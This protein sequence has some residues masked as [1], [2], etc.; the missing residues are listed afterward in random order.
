M[1]H[2]GATRANSSDRSK[3]ALMRELGYRP[4]S[5]AE[6]L[7]MALRHAV[8]RSRRH[9]QAKGSFM[10]PAAILS[11]DPLISYS[12][13]VPR[14][15]LGLASLAPPGKRDAW[16]LISPTWSTEEPATVRM[17]RRHA[18][19]HRLRHSH[20]RLIFLCNTPEEQR[21]LRE[22]GE[23]AVFLNKTLS[24]P[25]AIFRPIEGVS[26]EFDAIYNAQLAPWKRHELTLGIERCAFICYRAETRPERQAFETE[27]FA[28]HA[29][30]APGHVFLN[31]VDEGG[32]PVRFLPADVNRQLGRAAVGLCLSAREG[33]MF[34]STEYLLAGLPVVTTPS[35]GG[36]HIHFDPEYCL[37]VPPDPRSIAEAVAAMKAKEIPRGYVRERTLQRLDRDRCRFIELINRILVASDTASR[38]AMPWPFRKPV[39]MEW[40][41]AEA[42]VTR[43]VSGRVDAF[44]ALEQ[45][46]ALVGG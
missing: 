12:G 19:V 36:R 45:D 38:L 17:L 40:L 24:V 21:L 34:A 39:I 42:A 29:R 43:A 20:H 33:A 23:A 6:F 9:F 5:A 2:V 3:P 32:A 25:E 41:T 28:R 31:A 10:L 35:T 7:R 18:A 15:P 16:F 26:V 13:M 14:A 30:L 8:A 4:P 27:L 46:G 11:A 44:E 37:T 22:Q 1:E